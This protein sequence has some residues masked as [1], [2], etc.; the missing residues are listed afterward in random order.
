MTMEFS[1]RRIH[2]R[3][4]R[5]WRFAAAAGACG[6]FLTLEP[7]FAFAANECGPAAPAGTVACSAPTYPSGITYKGTSGLTVNVASGT[8]VTNAGGSGAIDLEGTGPLALNALNASTTGSGVNAN[9]SFSGPNFR[10]GIYYGVLGYSSTGPVALTIGQATT[11]MSGGAVGIGGYSNSGAVTIQTTHVQQTGL[12]AVGIN[13]EGASVSVTAGQ[14]DATL[15]GIVA[16]GDAGGVTVNSDTINVID[17]GMFTGVGIQ[18]DALSGQG[19]ISVTSGSIS[20]SGSNGVGGI[21]TQS[22]TV[23]GK[24]TIV[25]GSI[26]AIGPGQ[27]GISAIGPSAVDITS[28]GTIRTNGGPRFVNDPRVAGGTQTDPRFA[29][30]IWV[31]DPTNSVSIKN[32]GSIITTGDEAYGIRVE[33]GTQI[34]SIPDANDHPDSKPITITSASISTSGQG[35]DGIYIASDQSAVTLTSDTVKT[36]GAGSYGINISSSGGPVTV[37]STDAEVASGNLEHAIGINNTGGPVT[38][39]SGT[40]SG[41]IDIAVLAV[42]DASVTSASATST[43]DV[44][45]VVESFGKVTVSSQ[46]VIASGASAPGIIGFGGGDVSITSGFATTSGDSQFGR[47]AQAGQNVV[48]NAIAALSQ[49]GNV[50]IDGAT[51]S[52][53]GLYAAGVY[54]QADSGTVTLTSGSITTVGA[55]S[56]GIFATA[57]GATINSTTI[58]TSGASFAFPGGAGPAGLPLMTDV[59]PAATIAADG[60]DLS[61]GAGGATVTSGTITTAGGSGIEVLGGS[62]AIKIT[63]GTI[64]ASNGYGIFVSDG[65]GAVTLSST[66]LTSGGIGL[67]ANSS[68]AV[69]IASGTLASQ[70]SGI[71]ASGS[72]VSVTNTT[73]IDATLQGI[74]A[75]AGAGGVTIVSGIVNVDNGGVGP[76]GGVYADGINA[77]TSGG[78]ISITSS[79]SETTGATASA[80]YANNSGGSVTIDSSTAEGTG[81]GASGVVARAEGN[82][83]VTSATATGT[84]NSAINAQSTGGSI[85]VNSGTATSSGTSAAIYAIAT[86]GAVTINAGTTTAT[87]GGAISAQSDA[88]VKL[89]AQNISNSASGTAA[90]YVGN[91]GTSP[92][93]VANNLTLQSVTATGTGADAI[94][95]YDLQARTGAAGSFVN[96]IVLSG[97]S[98]SSSGIG[99]L[100]VSSINSNIANSGRISGTIGIKTQ[101]NGS[102]SSPPQ[103]SLTNGG[104][105]VGTSGTAVSATG[106][107]FVLVNTGTIDGSVSIDDGA[108]PGSLQVQNSGLITGDLTLHGY[109]ANVY[110]MPGSTVTGKVQFTPTMSV[111]NAELVLYAGVTVTG[112]QLSGFHDVQVGGD[113]RITVAGGPSALNA[114]WDIQ[115]G[116]LTVADDRALGTG[117][118]YFDYSSGYLQATATTT[119]NRSIAILSGSGFTGGFDVAAGATYTLNGVLTGGSANPSFNNAISVNGAG[120]TGELVFGR[121]N[122]AT[123]YSDINVYGGGIYAMATGAFGNG[124]IHIYDPEIGLADGVEIANDIDLQDN[125]QVD[126]AGGTGLLSGVISESVPGSGLTTAGG[127]T[128]LL[129]GANTYTGTTTIGGGTLA[130]VGDGSIAASSGVVDNG[131]L[132]ISQSNG[133]ASIPTLSGSGQVALGTQTLTLTDAT[134]TFAGSIS[135]TG[136]VAITGGTETLTGTNTYSGPTTV[137]DGSLVLSGSLPDSTV[138]L[139]SGGSLTGSGF[140]AALVAAP[141]SVLS[142]GGSGVGQLVLDTAALGFGSVTSVDIDGPTMGNYDRFVLTGAGHSFTAGG[143][144]VVNLRGI[145]PPASNNFTPV[146]GEQFNVVH[147]DAGVVGSFS[148]LT[149]PMAGLP[150]GTQFDALYSTT[151]IDLVV[152]P[153]SYAN[154]APLGVAET[155]NRLGVGGA[156]DSYRLAPGQRMTGDRN[157][158]LTALYGLPAG[159]IGASLDR[160]AGS[161]HGDVLNVALGMNRLFDSAI[162]DHRGAGGQ[163]VAFIDRLPTGTFA[164][165][166]T[167]ASPREASLD[168]A[169]PFWAIGLGSWS[170]ASGDGNAAGYSADAGG[171]LAGVDLV[172]QDDKAFGLAVGY[173]KS[174][175]RTKDAATATVQ[176]ERLTGYGD[177]VHGAWRLN[178]EV[179][180]AVDQ[181]RSKRLIEIGALTRTALGNSNGWAFAADGSLHYDLGFAAPFVEARYDY[182]SRSGFTETGAGDLSLIVQKQSLDTPRFT[183]GADF[184]LDGLASDT[185]STLVVNL[186]LAYAHDIKRIDGLSDAALAGSPLTGFTALSSRVGLDAGIATL[187]TSAQIND[188]VNLFGEYHVEVRS[189]QTSQ[190]VELGLRTE[191]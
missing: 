8:T 108:I 142:P 190:S 144:L 48:A 167:V 113:G 32:Q 140:V 68:G 115:G 184:D 135:G 147:T 126:Q 60:I 17:N 49:S 154:L 53:A 63:S 153:V 189:R 86:G 22:A 164:A 105:I 34:T 77:T 110:L 183:A 50:T 1:T 51:L 89:V 159:S 75:A 57:V 25:S 130:I 71:V 58:A 129:S 91:T 143:Q 36:T 21:S 187:N 175:V 158:V 120:G 27:Y 111:S 107:N 73:R 151:D 136:G 44:G 12:S 119:S 114:R 61:V 156:L 139:G 168:S 4:G 103:T 29:T 2:V 122:R 131:V 23:N 54:A 9:F 98:S 132:D 45:I 188:S 152:T 15:R 100:S 149:E 148:S 146:A 62:G 138:V 14:I 42:G 93:A 141:G 35:A 5:C 123:L 72:A 40:T 31:M 87:G 170:H 177:M 185:P 150:A 7:D 83:S 118:L 55:G 166:N 97:D 116:V 26:T 165:I 95:A 78:S 127:G 173:A 180:V 174:D 69:S 124:K 81:T 56:V 33:T 109:T 39:T 104:M 102:T 134:D 84:G 133:G 155:A 11:T 37:T 38:L 30:G 171:V 52:T 3:R 19:D 101:T 181:Y 80:I 46:S 59:A 182:V 99:L 161:V 176:T 65:T 106:G 125:L 117:P 76:V 157:T 191:W 85:T 82:I 66:T 145:T 92:N 137:T 67:Y 79:D 160:I 18:A 96:T 10:P 6:F 20:A 24:T 64:T 28:T 128:V 121:D 162:G 70:N 178:G 172:A 163:M 88:G 74:H 43:G 47:G 90:V 41:A 179:A 112:S 186:R 169:S 16:F 94:E 13:A